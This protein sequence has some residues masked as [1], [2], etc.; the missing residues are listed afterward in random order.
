MRDEIG[1]V[2]RPQQ[3]GSLSEGRYDRELNTNKYKRKVGTV[4]GLLQLV[5]RAHPAKKRP[6]PTM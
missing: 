6:W 5:S 4:Q 2:A 3:F 1:I